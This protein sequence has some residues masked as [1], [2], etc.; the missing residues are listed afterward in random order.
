MRYK[1]FQ[2]NIKVILSIIRLINI[3]L[4]IIKTGYTCEKK[5]DNGIG[6][7]CKDKMQL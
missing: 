1:I 3:K 6:Y 7:Y 4:I 2:S 5:N